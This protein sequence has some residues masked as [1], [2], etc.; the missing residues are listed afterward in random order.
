MLYLLSRS[1]FIFVLALVS[2]LAAMS[3]AWAES[4]LKAPEDNRTLV[5]LAPA[6]RDLF[7]QEMRR[8]LAH[9][10]DILSA[11]SDQDFELAARIAERKMG[12]AHR[13]IE[14]ME[15]DGASDAQI[16]G[17]I[18]KIRK[19]GARVGEMPVKEL[20][21]KMSRGMMGV[22]KFMP[23]ELQG[24]GQAFHL[25][26]YDVADAARLVAKKPDAASYQKLFSAINDMTTHCRGCHDA[27]RVR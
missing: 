10:D 24:V 26:A 27:Y 16:A 13:R 6:I 8:D 23:A 9:L 2:G 18:R 12:L 17:A 14:R 1:P 5:K 11:I 22:G 7:L 21:R 19:M 15:A 25:T 20:H 3:L 4:G